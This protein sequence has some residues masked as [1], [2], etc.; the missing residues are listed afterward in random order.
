MQKTLLLI[1]LGIIHLSCQTQDWP[2]WRGT[3][4]DGVWEASGIVEKFDSDESLSDKFS[5]PSSVFVKNRNQT[6]DRIRLRVKEEF[7]LK[8]EVFT[9]FLEKAYKASPR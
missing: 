7:D 9:K 3:N 8:A 1:V 6:S 2:D 4:R 5:M